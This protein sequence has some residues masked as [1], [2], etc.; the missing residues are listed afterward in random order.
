V[1]YCIFCCSLMLAVGLL[2]ARMKDTHFI[3]HFPHLYHSFG[4]RAVSPKD[5]SGSF[6]EDSHFDW[7][8]TYAISWR[9]DDCRYQQGGTDQLGHA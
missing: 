8:S 3:A 9:A 1:Q 6:S 4:C 5:P 7:I 2:W